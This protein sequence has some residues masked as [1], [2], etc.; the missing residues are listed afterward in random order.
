M[1][2]TTTTTTATK[3]DLSVL[4]FDVNEAAKRY[5]AAKKESS[6]AHRIEC[7][8]LNE[9]NEAQRK[10]DAAMSKLKQSAPRSSDWASER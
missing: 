6:Y 2:T 1:T 7:A 8:A 5:E 9:L 10:L 4:A 3:D